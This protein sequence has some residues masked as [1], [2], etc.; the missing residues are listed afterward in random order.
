MSKP[1]ARRATAWAMR[2]AAHEARLA[3]ETSWPSMNSGDQPTK[4]PARTRA[5]PSTPRRRVRQDQ[6]HRDVGGGVGEHSRGVADARCRGR[7]RR[8]RRRCRRP[9][10]SSRSPD[11]G[12]RQ[13]VGRQVVA[14]LAD[15]HGVL[16]G[17]QQVAQLL[18]AWAASR[19][20]RPRRRSRSISMP[21]SGSGTV[22]S[23]A[24]CR[25]RRSRSAQTRTAI[26]AM[27]SSPVWG[28]EWLQHVVAQGTQRGAPVSER[29]AQRC[30]CPRRSGCR[31][32]R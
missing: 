27:S 19:G 18:R 15:H 21:G 13:L 3:P 11:P 23:T 28:G 26:R 10:R 1:A 5:S 31:D 9:R 20:P 30:R 12:G 16:P 17:G 14:E 8:P 25:C 7:R 24:P 29:A 2:P 4:P 32:A 22:T 6:Q